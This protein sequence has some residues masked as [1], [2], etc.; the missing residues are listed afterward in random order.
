MY[1][2]VEYI[3]WLV[4]AFIPLISLINNFRGHS[5]GV[6]CVYKMSPYTNYIQERCV[7]EALVYESI[8]LE[9]LCV[10]DMWQRGGIHKLLFELRDNMFSKCTKNYTL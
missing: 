2:R 6:C 8:A 9:I 5:H 4:F 10:D 7:Y 3:E 1:T